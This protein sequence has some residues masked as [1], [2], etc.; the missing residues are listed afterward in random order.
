MQ[1][2]WQKKQIYLNFLQKGLRMSTNVRLNL[3]WAPVVQGG[4]KIHKLFFD[5][6]K[7]K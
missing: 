3:R 2:F 4:P 5:I 6:R 7:K 1:V